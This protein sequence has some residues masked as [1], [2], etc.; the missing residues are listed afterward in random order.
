MGM[1]QLQSMPWSEVAVDGKLV[2]TTPLMNLR[3]R[4]GT[5]R[6][7][8]TNPGCIPVTMTVHVGPLQS[9]ERNVILQRQ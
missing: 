9:V 7:T 5:H 2:G 4:A 1:L 6:L 3:V 8:F